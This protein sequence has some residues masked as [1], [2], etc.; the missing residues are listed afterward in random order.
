M[1]LQDSFLLLYKLDIDI[2]VYKLFLILCCPVY[3]VCSFKTN[4]WCLIGNFIPPLLYFDHK[5]ANTFSI[6]FLFHIFLP[7]TNQQ[8]WKS[9]AILGPADRLQGT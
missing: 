1:I 6:L 4:A 7:Q 3:M 9:K 5:V 2:G 8:M